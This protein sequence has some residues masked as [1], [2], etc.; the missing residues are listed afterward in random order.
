M[1]SPRLCA[2]QRLQVLQALPALPAQA[3]LLRQALKKEL[4][5]PFQ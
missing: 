5:Q 3:F 1:A 4:A 2:C